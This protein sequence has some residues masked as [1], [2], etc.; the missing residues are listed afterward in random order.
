MHPTEEVFGKF[1]WGDDAAKVLHHYLFYHINGHTLC[2]FDLMS[3][4][5]KHTEAHLGVKLNVSTYQHL[6]SAVGRYFHLGIID[7]HDDMM[8]G[9]DAMAGHQMAT[10][11]LIYGLQP[12]EVGGLS[13]CVIALFRAMAHL[14]HAKVL[15]LNL[16]GRVATMDQILSRDSSI[17][18]LAGTAPVRSFGLRD[19][20]AIVDQVK[21]AFDES[22]TTRIVPDLIKALED[23]VADRVFVE[24]IQPPQQPR[25]IQ[26]P[27][28]PQQ[29][30]RAH[31][32]DPVPPGPTWAHLTR[33][34]AHPLPATHPS[35]LFPL[36]SFSFISLSLS[37]YSLFTR[38][39]FPCI[40]VL[41]TRPARTPR[42]TSRYAQHARTPSGSP[43][44][45][46]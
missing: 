2:T 35:S 16:E 7:L 29:P 44:G 23:K 41:L 26:Q 8:T 20:E 36:S 15:G 3:I 40:I 33:S 19:L 25:Q 14:W 21:V 46:P 39:T 11:E 45:I 38:T 34:P 24:S 9:M 32:P 43:T 28:H 17:E 18:E 1:L 37:V 27:P 10:S 5:E 30:V 22:V 6:A 4:M 13:P 12:E 42:A 31:P